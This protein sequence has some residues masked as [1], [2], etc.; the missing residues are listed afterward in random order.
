[1]T[2]PAH[3]ARAGP[4]S[5]TV[6]DVEHHNFYFTIDREWI[7]TFI[8]TTIINNNTTLLRKQHTVC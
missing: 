8:E 2:E 1:M 5:I 4:V 7:A 3:T 6:I